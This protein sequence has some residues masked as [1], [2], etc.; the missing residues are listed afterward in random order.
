MDNYDISILYDMFPNATND[1]ELDYE[2][3]EAFDND[4]YG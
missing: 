1:D 3:S 2:L 4:C